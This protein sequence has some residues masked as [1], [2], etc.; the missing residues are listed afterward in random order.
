MAILVVVGTAM[1]GPFEDAA[2]AYDSGDYATAIRLYRP[3]ADQGHADAQG[4]LAVMYFRGDGVPENYAEAVKWYRK[5][6]DQ[7]NVGAQADLG[8]MYEEG[9]GVRQSYVQAHMWYNLAAAAW[10]KKTRRAEAIEKAMQEVGPSSL[11]LRLLGFE[12]RNLA[13]ENRDK[14]A[15]KMTPE[16]IAEAQKLASEWKP[17][18]P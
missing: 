1:A 14:L 15:R 10:P 13:A 16:Q 9:L 17:K 6:A 8:I 5:A 12:S 3:L 18:P 4:A 2:R 7:G 11:A